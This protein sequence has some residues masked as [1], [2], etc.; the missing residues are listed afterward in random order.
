MNST[1]KRVGVPQSRAP[2][3]RPAGTT[4]GSRRAVARPARRSQSW[5]ATHQPSAPSRASTSG[6]AVITASPS[7]RSVS[8]TT[9]HEEDQA[10]HWVL[11]DFS[12]RVEQVVAG[13]VGD[14]QVAAR[15]ETTRRSPACRPSATPWCAPSAS[16]VATNANRAALDHRPR[17]TARRWSSF[18]SATSLV[19]CAVQLP[20]ALRRT[21]S[22]AVNGAST[23]TSAMTHGRLAR[24]ELQRTPCGRQGLHACSRSARCSPRPRL[25]HGRRRMRRR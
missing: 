4:P 16:A 3:A 2:T 17:P 9:R 11:D 19:G 14:R 15:R 18:F 22:M 7:T 20:Q 5:A 1:N 6:A 23:A 13:E 8:G 12:Q 10:D 25:R 21:R 24:A